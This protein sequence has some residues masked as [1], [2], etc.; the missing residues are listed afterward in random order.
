MSLTENA[1]D[2]L[3]ILKLRAFIVNKFIESDAREF[4]L[5]KY[6]LADVLS[7]S[8]EKKEEII[9]K[10]LYFLHCANQ[11]IG[12]SAIN[13]ISHFEDAGEPALPHLRHCLTY[14]MSEQTLISLLFHIQTILSKIESP[15]CVELKSSLELLLD[16]SNPDVRHNAEECIGLLR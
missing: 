7:K 9:G 13:I 1:G 5:M 16:C 14:E 6:G 15:I 2:V 12:I 11:D 8:S 10:L 3:E 4:V